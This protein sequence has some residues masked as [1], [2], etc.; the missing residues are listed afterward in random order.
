MTAE[1]LSWRGPGSERP[2]LPVP[3]GKVPLRRGGSWRKRWRYLGAFSEELLRSSPLSLVQ[4]YEAQQ[5]VVRRSG[6]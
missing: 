1:G 3:P 4:S 2:D 5:L 6:G